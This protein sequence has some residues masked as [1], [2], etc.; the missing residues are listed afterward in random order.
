MENEHENSRTAANLRGISQL[1]A[2]PENV[3]GEP[4][5]CDIVKI[6]RGR[7]Q[8]MVIQKLLKEAKQ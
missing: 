6:V 1:L 4:Y 2:I 3:K 5:Y 8:I 7:D